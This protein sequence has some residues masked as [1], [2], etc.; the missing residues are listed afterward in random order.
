MPRT[1]HLENLRGLDNALPTECNGFHANPERA[2]VPLNGPGGRIAILELKR[3]GRLPDGPLAAFFNTCKVLDFA[4]DPFDNRRLAVACEDGRIRLWDVKGDM[5]ESS[6]EPTTILSVPGSTDRITAIQFHPLA[7]AVLASVS[8]DYVLRVWD[9]SG[10]AADDALTIL[11]QMEPHPDQVFSLA[12]SPCGA[13]IATV[14]KDGRVRIFEPRKSRSAVRQGSG[15]AGVKGAR[16]CW[17]LDGQFLLVSG[18]DKSS[19]RL[20]YVFRAADLSA[21]LATLNLDVSP[22]LLVPYYDEDSATLFLTGKGDTTIQCYE[23]SP[24]PPHTFPLSHHKCSTALQGLAL[25]PKSVV[26][27]K[28]VEF[29]RFVTLTSGSVEPLSFAVPRVKMDYF[30]DDLFPPTKVTWEPALT[31]RQWADGQDGHLKRM[32]LKPDNMESLSSIKPAAAPAKATPA[33]APVAAPTIPAGTNGSSGGFMSA[34]SARKER[35]RGAQLEA[36]ISSQL[37]VNL[38]LEQDGMEGVDESEWVTL[39]FLSKIVNQILK[40]FFFFPGQLKNIPK[41]KPEGST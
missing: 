11:A 10:T 40:F 25:L 35:E 6:N 24:D 22:T 31:V 8:A 33:A 19:Q 30:Q 41:R 21:P 9:A 5:L 34:V 12:W 1:T 23:I 26:Q 36:A 18:F 14:C 4:W 29:A 16:V 3:T 15:P 7:K 17:A 2:A 38:A 32:D 13:F 20:L 28:D 27:V 37:E 39:F